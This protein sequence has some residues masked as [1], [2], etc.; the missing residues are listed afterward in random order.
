MPTLC[1]WQFKLAKL[2]TLS[3]NSKAS[4]CIERMKRKSFSPKSL[5]CSFNTTLGK[6]EFFGIF[7]ILS[8]VF[9][10]DSNV[11]NF[12]YHGKTQIYRL[13]SSVRNWIIFKVTETKIQMQKIYDL[14]GIKSKKLSL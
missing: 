1:C 11:A 10:L 2:A 12:D 8:N 6:N 14:F 5:M 9:E 7:W 13:V 3:S 4:D